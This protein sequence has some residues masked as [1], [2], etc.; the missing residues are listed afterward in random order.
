MRCHIIYV[1]TSAG[2]IEYV[3]GPYFIHPLDSRFQWFLPS[4][5]L[6]LKLN[7]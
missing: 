4:F 3:H 7:Q 1:K 2:R 6:F 5:A